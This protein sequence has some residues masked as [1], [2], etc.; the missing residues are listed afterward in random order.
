MYKI[1]MV[2]TG[3]V[4]QTHP[5]KD[6]ADDKWPGRRFRATLVL[7]T[8][9]WEISYKTRNKRVRWRLRRGMR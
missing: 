5:I 1:K 7:L 4:S 2:T 3:R 8:A 9:L 6:F